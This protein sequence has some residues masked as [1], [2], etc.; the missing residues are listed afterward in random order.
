MDMTEKLRLS[1]PLPISKL[2]E[3]MQLEAEPQLRVQKMLFLFEGIFRYLALIGLASY[4]HHQLT[5]PY[6]EEARIGLK[7]PSL[8]NWLGL[9]RNTASLLE[10]TDFPLLVNGFHHKY[11][12][13]SIL[14][15][16]RVL[17]RTLGQKHGWKKADL[18]KFLGT[19]VEFR[20][21]KIA[22]PNILFPVREAR[23]V[24]TSLEAA[25]NQWLKELAILHQQ[26]LVYIDRVEWQ[27]SR[28]VYYGTN[29]NSGTSLFRLELVRNKPVAPGQVYLHEPVNDS[30]M[31]LYPFFVFD[32]DAHLL[33]IYNELSDKGELILRCP[34]KA[35]GARAAH[36]LEC[37]ESI[38]MG[39]KPTPETPTSDDAHKSPQ[40][41]TVSKHEKILNLIKTNLTENWLTDSQRK[42]WMQL[43]KFMEPPYYVVNIY[44]V[45]GTG[46]TF[47]GW[48]LQKQGRAIYADAGDPSW[49]SWKGQDLGPGPMSSHHLHV[50]E[51][52]PVLVEIGGGTEDCM[53]MATRSESQGGLGWFASD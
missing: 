48:L 8:G 51:S 22:H 34:Y 29:L 25:I 30:L 17:A 50:Q 15:A 43:S 28:F 7:K 44:G 53:K 33:Y 26:H 46:K 23:E 36:Y 4:I 45:S 35:P 41:A 1:Y 13:D 32:S 52:I 12:D 2:Y 38:I 21:K 42:V 37:D 18:N 3:I 27:D 47:L 16:T 10:S 24:N 49:Q 40:G 11:E 5:D 9:L 31:P 14:E 20:N 19:V 39:I 6:V